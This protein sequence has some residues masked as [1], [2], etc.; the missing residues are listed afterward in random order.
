MDVQLRILTRP[1]EVPDLAPALETYATQ[2]MAEFRDGP[3]PEGVGVQALTRAMEASAGVA[4]TAHGDGGGRIGFCVVV[5][6]VDPLL[7]DAMPMVVALWTEVDHRHRGLA[8]QMVQAARRDLESRGHHILAS[9]AG[10][11]D[12]ALISMGER[13]GFVRSWELMVRE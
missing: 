5:P 2:V 6:F 3:V 13:W 4:L 7:G 10:H 1:E 12:D 9:R 11:N 8:G